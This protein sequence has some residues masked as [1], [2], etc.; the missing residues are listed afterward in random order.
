MVTATPA[1]VSVRER[2]PD[3]GKAEARE[4]C[5]VA[6]GELGNAVMAQGQG[7]ARVED[8]TTPNLRLASATPDFLHDRGTPTWMINER[9]SRVLTQAL[10]EGD[11]FRSVEWILKDDGVAEEHVKFDQHQFANGDFARRGRK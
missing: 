2:I 6:R 8:H 10:D 11:G 9:P 4:V 7:K 5:F 1:A 3:A